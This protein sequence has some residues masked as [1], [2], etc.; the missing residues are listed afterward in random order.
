MNFSLIPPSD[1][2]IYGVDRRIE[3]QQSD[4]IRIY[5]YLLGS[6]GNHK[7]TQRILKMTIWLQS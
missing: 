1:L 6:L 7:N 4:P 2:E 5:F 3:E